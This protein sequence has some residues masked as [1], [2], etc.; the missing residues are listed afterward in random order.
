[1]HGGA[2]LDTPIAVCG[3]KTE[4]S[5]CY[6]MHVTDIGLS[7]RFM[8]RYSQLLEVSPCANSAKKALVAPIIHRHSEI[9]EASLLPNMYSR[10]Y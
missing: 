4:R 6:S 9:L 1:M 5:T 10:P 7:V 8:N 2:V 3:I